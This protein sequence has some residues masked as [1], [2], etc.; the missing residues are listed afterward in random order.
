MCL[1]CMF[2]SSKHTRLLT[3]DTWLKESI[4]TSNAI[5][6]SYHM[7]SYISTL[8]RDF[9]VDVLIQ[10]RNVSCPPL[11]VMHWIGSSLTIFY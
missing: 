7:L 1:F 10:I 9:D 4:I 2:P 6:F 5:S 11:C 3:S 8:Y